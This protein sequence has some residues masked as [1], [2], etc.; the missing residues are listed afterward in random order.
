MILIGNEIGIKKDFDRKNM[1]APDF[2]VVKYSPNLFH[3]QLCC[4]PGSTGAR[5]QQRSR[6]RRVGDAGDRERQHQR[7]R[8]YDRGKRIRPHQEE[9]D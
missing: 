9:V 3:L 7:C 8:R 1:A 5:P 4:R 6:R 2:F